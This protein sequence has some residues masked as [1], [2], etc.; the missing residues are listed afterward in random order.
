MRGAL[1]ANTQDC[2]LEE[3]ELMRGGIAGYFPLGVVVGWGDP[4]GG[5]TLR[6]DPVGSTLRGDPV[7]S[8]LHENLVGSNL[9][10]DRVGS[11]LCEDQVGSNLCEDQVGSNLCED[12]VGS[13]LCGELVGCNLCEDRVGSNLCEEL[14]S[15]NLCE[16]LV[17]S[18]LCEDLVGGTLREAPVVV[19]DGELGGDPAV[20]GEEQN[21][22]LHPYRLRVAHHQ[23]WPPARRQWSWQPSADLFL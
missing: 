15:S 19:V 5:S 3:G 4:A 16:D 7:G 12:Q 11:N 17:G 6:G 13:N 20:R 18:N 9:C 10:E 21:H 2:R 8:D 1:L 22:H 14:V 23:I